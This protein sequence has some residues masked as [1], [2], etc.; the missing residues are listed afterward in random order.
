MRI[1][2]AFIIIAIVF[3]VS[4]TSFLTNFLFTRQ[5]ITDAVDQDLSLAIDIADNLVS[6]KMLLIKA[7][8]ATVAARLMKAGSNEEMS[9]IMASEI[10]KFPE[11]TALSVFDKEHGV[12]ANYG[13]PITT[14]ELLAESRYVNMAYNGESVI[15]TTRYNPETNV[16]IM[17]VFV[18][19]TSDMAM[20]ATISGFSFSDFI[21][22][23]K[24]WQTGSMFMLDEEGTIIADINDE[25]VLRRENF[26]KEA[27]VNSG[28]KDLITKS[29]ILKQ[30]LSI[31]KGR[32]TFLDHGI[33]YICQY[34]RISGTTANWHVVVS[35]PIREGPENK[36][37]LD[38]LYSSLIFL[39]VGLLISIFAS[40]IVVR[41][42]IQI[43]EQ[44]AKIL[45][46]HKRTNL[47]LNAMPLSCH[48]WNSN[49]EMYYC[50]DENLR[51]F[52]QNST[53][54]F[55][56]T[57]HDYSPEYQDDGQL[58]SEKQ[59]KYIN[60]AFAEGRYAFE[61]KYQLKDGTV[62]PTEITLVRIPFGNEM[63][64][65]AYIRDMRE[66]K[67]MISEI[68]QRDKHLDTINKIAA[69]LLKSGI[70][71]FEKDLK[72]CMSM[73]AEAIEVDRVYISENYEK[74][75]K[76]FTTQLYEWSGGAEPQQDTV[77]TVDVPYDE[78]LPGWKAVLSQGKCINRVVRNMSGDEQ[79]QLASQGINSIL[80][81]PVFMSD[82]FWGFIGFDDCHRERIFTENEQSILSSAG[83]VIAYAVF[84]NGM[85]K[86]IRASAAKLEAV[87]N[88]YSGIIW[89]VDKDMTITLYQG[90]YLNM[91]SPLSYPAEGLKLEEFLNRE[92]NKEQKNLIYGNILKTFTEGPKDWIVKINGKRMRFRSTPTYDNAGNEVT[93]VYGSI[94]DITELSRLQAELEA[95][96][97]EAREANNAKTEFLA[98]M[99]HE[100]RT[101]LN[102]IIGLSEMSLDM[103]RGDEELY[104]NLEKV[105][106][107]GELLLSTVNDILDIAKI[108]AGKLEL[109][110]IEYDTPSLINDTITQN[111]LRIG[112]KPVKFVLD[113]AP[114]FPTHLY[115]DEVRI[116]QL[117]NNLLSNAFKYTRKGKVELKVTCERESGSD[118][119]WLIIRVEDSGIGI[120]PD[121]VK[122]LFSD[123]SQVDTS[124]NRTIEGTGLGLSITK[125]IV[126]MMDGSITVESEYGNGS[127]FTAK[128]KQRYI[129]DSTIGEEVV[130]NLKNFR[131]SGNKRRKKSML[132][133]N[134]IPYARV[135]V[136]DDVQT[137][138]DVARGMLRPYGMHI[139]CVS[140]GQEA[141]NA[142][143]REKVKYDIVFM[144]HMMPDMDGIE[145]TRII[146]EKIGT[147]YA[148]TVPI[149]ALTA[150]AIAG[151]EKMFLDKGFQAF[152]SKPIDVMRLD[153]ILNT[154]I[155]KKQPDDALLQTVN[156]SETA[157]ETSADTENNLNIINDFSVDGVDLIQGRERFVNETEYLNVIRSYYK[158]TPPLLEKMKTFSINS[159]FTKRDIDAS[160]IS[161]A[162]IS[163]HE[164]T[165]IAHSI[166]G[167]SYSISANVA[168]S[169]AAELEAAARAGD[170]NKIITKNSAFITMMESLLKDLGKILQ[171]AASLK[172]VQNEA[173]APDTAL[174]S[175]LLKATNEYKAFE[176]NQIIGELESYKYESG[177]ELICWLRDQMDNLDY[178]AIRERLEAVV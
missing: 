76:L 1:K 161:T 49:G 138:L 66:Q 103:D 54:E 27:E 151:N 111:I 127:V 166:K 55:L 119:V 131:Y 51:L 3:V 79:A 17:H 18:P 98:R 34:K 4:I 28:D 154:W 78:K 137:N 86:S 105:Y 142:I 125:K 136:V 115:G 149:I 50:N 31:E 24:L 62:V 47:L 5:S 97:I 140:S 58:S 25:L 67:K 8:G 30:I 35:A 70:D 112:E 120:R 46:A 122:K 143:S 165:R 53:E 121:E 57:Y 124:V 89:G 80:I 44:S 60:Q 14:E 175:Q 10:I 107:A 92:M 134:K 118:V 177:S 100:M 113:I 172:K 77:Y 132:V 167:A 32:G 73:I 39:V 6:S 48:L 33:E 170:V 37:M 38:L 52:N 141:I 163:L 74:D 93:N 159:S 160:E 129:D 162:G 65:A 147:A 153:S 22:G 26:I 128:F 126:K 9:E 15:P 16:F 81:L 146:R 91:L 45:E 90:R 102:A 41:P 145:A 99:S 64:V 155:P 29:D 42:F 156:E 176:M 144:D 123:Y 117:F 101:P 164:Y 158:H 171:K 85:T 19:M 63:V 40:Q 36:V 139:D 82:K 56:Q 12:I 108:E 110:P 75:G 157:G 109:I 7:N 152:I 135:L 95:A 173:P 83:N 2:A 72:L 13:I 96:L 94:D 168:G 114:S 174:L 59:K 88:N 116:K 150:N 104:P 23:Y 178:D 148:R 43:K 106:E 71:E 169:E 61:W 20:V 69:I 130:K 133:R 84:Q 11:F 68:E 87:V 21:R